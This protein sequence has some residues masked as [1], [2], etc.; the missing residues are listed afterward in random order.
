MERVTIAGDRPYFDQLQV[1]KA[2]SP[3]GPAMRRDRF[4]R[5]SPAEGGGAQR[6]AAR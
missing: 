3:V 5:S 6:S 4:S 2:A 1:A